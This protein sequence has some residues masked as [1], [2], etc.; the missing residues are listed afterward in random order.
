[1]LLYRELDG[2]DSEQQVEDFRR[3]MQD[4]FGAIPEEGEELIRVVALRHLGRRFGSERIV[5]KDGRMRLFFVRNPRAPSTR[6]APLANSST[7]PRCTR[8]IAVWPSTTGGA[9]CWCIPSAV[10]V[11]R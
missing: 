9:R 5:L 8:R 4:R 11:R 1:M 3:R 2:L 6:A 7:T 10:S